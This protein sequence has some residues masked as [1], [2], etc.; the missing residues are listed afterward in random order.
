ME[1]VFG[2]LRLRIDTLEINL[3][4]MVKSALYDRFLLK[5]IDVFASIFIC[6]NPRK[7]IISDVHIT[8]KNTFRM[9][10]SMMWC[11]DLDELSFVKTGQ[12]ITL[13]YPETIYT[14][15]IPPKGSQC[16]VLKALKKITLPFRNPPVSGHGSFSSYWSARKLP[17]VDSLYQHSQFIHGLPQDVVFHLVNRDA[18]FRRN[19]RTS[20]NLKSPSIDGESE[21]QLRVYLA[22]ERRKTHGLKGLD[23]YFEGRMRNIH[24]F[25][26]EE[27]EKMN[28]Y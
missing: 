28:P 14:L 20:S 10:D 24:F 2:S 3:E 25:T 19:S 15:K 12:A 7:L 8:V 18:S 23:E 16:V 9:M 1:M 26:M 27:Y 17:D 13:P 22:E 6:F 4:T 21:E 11:M 5:M